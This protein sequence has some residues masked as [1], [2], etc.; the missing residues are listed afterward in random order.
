MQNLLLTLCTICI[1][2]C[3]WAEYSA[4]PEQFVRMR[5]STEKSLSN[6]LFWEGQSFA[7]QDQ[8]EQRHLFDIFGINLSRCWYDDKTKQ[9]YF[10]SRELQYYVDPDTKLPIYTWQNPWTNETNNVVHVAND[11]V[12]FVIGNDSVSFPY[13]VQAKNMAT[14]QTTTNLFYPNPL[15]GVPELMPYGGWY[16]NYE[17]SEIFTFFVPE[18]ELLNASS[19]FAPG[20]HFSWTRVS[21]W[22]P[23]MKMNGMQGSMLFNAVGSRTEFGD[24]PQWLQAD[25]NNRL[26]LY[27]NAP[28][29]MLAVPDVTSWSY[30]REHFDDY[31]KGSQF[32][33][34]VSKA[35]PCQ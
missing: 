6:I 4:T 1:F 22:L 34:P 31:K 19:S 29:C 8:K 16:K 18:S 28:R 17:G 27:H 33:F 15:Y 14:F 7:V 3:G 5:C 26:P 35:P 23:F 12:Q 10:T 21:Q 9:W 2:S 24:L 30:F 11:P 13:N 32:P 20:L 25:I